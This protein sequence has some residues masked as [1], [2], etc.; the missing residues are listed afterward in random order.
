MTHS[1]PDS[2]DE[3]LRL[4]EIFENAAAVETIGRGHGRLPVGS[5][6]IIAAA[7]RDQAAAAFAMRAPAQAA[8]DWRDDPS[9]D[10]RWNAGVDFVMKLLCDYLGVD[11]AAVTWDAAT[12]TVE[13]DV[14][15]V[16]GNILR[17]K[18]GEDWGPAAASKVAPD[19][20]AW[21]REDGSAATI[22]PM[23]A[24]GWKAQGGQAV[25]LYA[26]LPQIPCTV[27]DTIIGPHGTGIC[28]QCG[29][30]ILRVSKLAANAPRK[31]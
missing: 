20:D 28:R 14:S 11:P 26:A 8:S 15:A 12:E 29:E 7:L 23:I 9:A 31:S 6:K 1:S 10:E 24:A 16:I 17:A 22:N 13:G 2:I 21:M 4:A 18:Y 5:A 19:P 27:H 25:P 3:C 30:T